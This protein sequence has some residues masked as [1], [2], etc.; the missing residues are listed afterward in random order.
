MFAQATLIALVASSPVT[1]FAILDAELIKCNVKVFL[2]G[3]GLGE[4]VMKGAQS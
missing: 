2:G 1:T 3:S 4:P